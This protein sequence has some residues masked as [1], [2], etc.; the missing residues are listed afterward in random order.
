MAWRIARETDGY[1]AD[2]ASGKGAASTGGRWNR[3]GT[4][5]VY[6]AA[7]VGIACLE[8][9]IKLD[10]DQPADNRYLTRYDIPESIWEQ[11][12]RFSASSA[13]VGW[14]ATPPGKTSH[15][16]G[17]RWIAESRSAILLVPSVI[18]PEE[19]NVLINPNHA[20]MTRIGITKLRKW[21]YDFRLVRRRLT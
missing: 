12:L 21:I 18:V 5:V 9:L 13:S 17:E 1:T 3:H 7:N 10:P 14:D 4:S 19:S 6:C 2:D 11:A 8:T 15:D 16:L 20:D